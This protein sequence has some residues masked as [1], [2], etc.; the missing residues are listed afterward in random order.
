MSTARRR[1]GIDLVR[2]CAGCRKNSTT[3]ISLFECNMKQ[4]V[5]FPGS[6]PALRSLVVLQNLANFDSI[7]PHLDDIEAE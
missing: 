4:H 2:E 6:C 5:A 1:A 7:Q 3:R